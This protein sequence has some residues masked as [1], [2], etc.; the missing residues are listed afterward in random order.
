ML[1]AGLLLLDCSA[2]FL[3]ELK[4][5]SQ[6]I[7]PP[8]MGPP[9][10]DHKLRKCLTVGSHGGIFLRE[11]PF[12][13]ITPDCVKLTHKT[14]RYRNIPPFLVGMQ[15]CTATMDAL[16]ISELIYLKTQLYH[17]LS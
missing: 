9:T 17:C 6:V 14:N 13:V 15:T 3:I 2:C 10:L 7:V 1:L 11:A 8:T 16:E 12:S 4:T 5:T